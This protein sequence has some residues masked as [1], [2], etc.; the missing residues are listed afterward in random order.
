M[1]SELTFS[2]VDID[3]ALEL[4]IRK[5][6][7]EENSLLVEAE[8]DD[9]NIDKMCYIADGGFDFFIGMISGNYIPEQVDRYRYINPSEILLEAYPDR[10]KF[11][12]GKVKKS[13]V[14]HLFQNLLTK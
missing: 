3:E 6:L 13:C 4:A 7:Y 10:K 1:I 8:Q 12:F 14:L 11:H 2:P 9:I 5:I